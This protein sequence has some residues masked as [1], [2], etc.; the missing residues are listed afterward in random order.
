MYYIFS[1]ILIREKLISH[2]QILTTIYSPKARLFFL[3]RYYKTT[4]ST[5][6]LTILVTMNNIEI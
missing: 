5:M 3:D 6:K 1:I 2:K 4:K